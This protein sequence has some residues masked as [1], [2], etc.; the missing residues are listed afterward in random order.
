MAALET[1]HAD[2]QREHTAASGALAAE[3]DAWLA[4]AAV[5]FN[6]E[7]N[8]E[9]AALLGA[10]LEEKDAEV[11]AAKE[12]MAA[13]LGGNPAAGLIVGA[14]VQDPAAQAALQRAEQRAFDAERRA[15]D[16]Q[17]Q[18]ADARS[19]AFEL[20]RQLAGEHVRA[21]AAEERLAAAEAR[22]SDLKARVAVADA[23]AAGCLQQQLNGEQ[24]SGGDLLL[25]IRDGQQQGGA[26]VRGRG[27]AEAAQPTPQQQQQKHHQR[28][29]P[30]HCEVPEARTQRA[31]Q[32]EVARCE[33]QQQELDLRDA[34]QLQA[35]AGQTGAPTAGHAHDPGDV[36]LPAETALAVTA[37]T[38]PAAAA[39]PP[40]TLDEL[41][42]VVQSLSRRGA[43]LQA[44]LSEPLRGGPPL[45]PLLLA[46]FSALAAEQGAA[47]YGV[48]AVVAHVEEQVSA[49]VRQLQDAV[50]AAA[51]V[52]GGGSAA[53]SS[54]GGGGGQEE[55][56]SAI[57]LSD[58]MSRRALLLDRGL[59]AAMRQV[60]VFD[61]AL[62]RR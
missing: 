29:H 31:L 62:T 42:A 33:Q 51:H 9:V 14:G 11:A 59:A 46:E 39:Q 49:L 4:Q 40:E 32:Q 43:A 15:A 24:L 57:V 28:Q 26:L 53:H 44:A 54:D 45:P 55:V 61:A 3:K 60:S 25:P 50:G 21:S 27:D 34:A 10:L 16:L 47:V 58:D 20:E 13:D 48:G 37:S 6:A 36:A 56:A 41:L 7:K 18:A 12:A 8:R 30:Q 38:A 2:A 52:R 19:D 1:A 22:V 5:A 23:T 17:G 35:G